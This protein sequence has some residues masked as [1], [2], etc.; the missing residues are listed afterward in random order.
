MEGSGEVV[1]GLWKP[2]SIME[3]GGGAKEK[4]RLSSRRDGGMGGRLEMAMLSRT[5]RVVMPLLIL[6]CERCSF[7]V[8]PLGLEV[9]L[10]SSYS[11]LYILKREFILYCEMSAL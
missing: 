9:F 5:G 4:M 10:V 2:A 6:E 3:G 8:M 7:L 11:G 1:A